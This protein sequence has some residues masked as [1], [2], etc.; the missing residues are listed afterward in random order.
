MRRIRTI[1]AVLSAPV[2]IFNRETPCEL[3]KSR[4]RSSAFPLVATH[5][6]TKESA[7]TRRSALAL[8]RVTDTGGFSENKALPSVRVRLLANA[9]V[10]VGVATSLYTQLKSRLKQSDRTFMKSFT[11]LIKIKVM[12][13][14]YYIMYLYENN[15]N[16]RTL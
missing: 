6:C 9:H 11:G 12:R 7:S 13:L 3:R 15:L 8:R 5:E 4:Q 16:Q 1:D 10:C 2:G 14:A